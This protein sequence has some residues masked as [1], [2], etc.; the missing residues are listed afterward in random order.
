[1]MLLLH[2]HITPQRIQARFT[3]RDTIVFILPFKSPF[4]QTLFIDPKRRFAFYLLNDARQRLCSAQ[5]N[6]AM[7]M[8]EIT[9][10]PIKVNVL[11][12]A[13]F[14]DMIKHDRPDFVRKYRVPIFG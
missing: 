6:D 7:C 3:Y 12:A 8:V 2:I 1:M 9:I 5:R 14:P 13:G 10:Y 4:G 11:G